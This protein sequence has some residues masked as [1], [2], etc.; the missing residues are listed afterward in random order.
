MPSY[1]RQPRN[2]EQSLLYYLDVNLDVD[3]SGTTV[4]KTFNRVYAKDIE[5]PI[6]CVR[7]S[8]TNSFR[9]EIGNVDLE[10]RYLLI[11]DMFVTSDAMRLDMADYIVQKLKS[12]W[13]YYDHAHA[14]GDNTEI[15]RVAG[16][17]CHVTDWITNARIDLG[18]NVDTK[19]RYRHNI[20]IRVRASTT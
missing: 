14:S 5:L 6:V 12:G 13:I 16:G 2:V 7:L 11:I 15:T 1:F 4:V 3:W 10:E 18:D 8:D 9:K 19:D 20:S 17:R